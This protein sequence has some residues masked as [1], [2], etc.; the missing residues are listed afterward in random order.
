G[1]RSGSV[2]EVVLFAR[3]TSQPGGVRALVVP[4]NGERRLRLSA[5]A[6]ASAGIAHGGFVGAAGHDR[7]RRGRRQAR[8]G[9]SAPGAGS[10]D[11]GRVAR[12][13]IGGRPDSAHAEGG[14]GPLAKGAGGHLPRE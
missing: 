13:G 2:P 1:C 3:S 9:G 8:S 6:K 4:P 11:G 14:G 10:R 7:R 12:V 5:K